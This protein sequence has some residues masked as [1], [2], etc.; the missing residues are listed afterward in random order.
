MGHVRLSVLLLGLLMVPWPHAAFTSF[1]LLSF[2]PTHA[3]TMVFQ[4]TNH[5]TQ[6][7]GTLTITLEPRLWWCDLPVIPWVFT[8]SHP[9]LYWRPGE[10]VALRWYTVAP[11]AVVPD[12][13]V[14]NTMLWVAGARV[15]DQVTGVETASV[16]Y[17]SH[18]TY[19][20]AFLGVKEASVPLSLR[21]EGGQNVLY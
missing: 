1:H 7:T 15:Y 2:F 12:Q 8:K 20:P 10:D 3:G 4:S 19:A 6:T 13:P 18:G 14:L 21:D 16:L 9:D 17:R 11:E 5:D